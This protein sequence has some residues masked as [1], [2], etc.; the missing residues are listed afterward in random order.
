[1]TTWITDRPPTKADGDI[2][3][4]VLVRMR[5]TTQVC[6]AIHWAYVSSGTPWRHTTFWVEPVAAP[7]PTAPTTQPRRFASLTPLNEGE[8]GGLVAVADDGTAWCLN[9]S[10]DKWT[11]LPALPER[12]TGVV[13]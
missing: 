10:W 4:D 13:P 11:Q 12:E 6:M 9:A 1:M 2:D 3:G 7:E 8:G 5:P